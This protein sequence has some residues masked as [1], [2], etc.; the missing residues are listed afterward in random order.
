MLQDSGTIF[1]DVVDIFSDSAQIKIGLGSQVFCYCAVCVHVREHVC[2]VFCVYVVNTGLNA[3]N[4]YAGTTLF[5]F[6]RPYSLFLS[7]VLTTASQTVV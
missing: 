6:S 4:R 7:S 3:M 1:E 5:F 2:V